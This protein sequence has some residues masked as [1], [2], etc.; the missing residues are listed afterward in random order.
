MADETH[1]IILR[2]Q[3]EEKVRALQQAL[4]QE[5][6]ALRSLV[7]QLN[8]RGLSHAQFAAQAQASAGKVVALGND[9]KG[10]QRSLD[11]VGGSA[12]GGGSKILGLAYALDDA[13]Q[14]NVSFVAGLRAISNN[15]PG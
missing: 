11:A 2:T 14:F 3:G 1:N 5:E 12:Q 13:Q 6:E 8:A 9:L 4:A 15:I 7:Q 10:A